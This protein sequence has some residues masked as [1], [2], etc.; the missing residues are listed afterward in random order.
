MTQKHTHKE[1]KE[2]EISTCKPPKKLT[3]KA[4]VTHLPAKLKPQKVAQ[5]TRFR[6]TRKK[7][8]NLQ[9]SQAQVKF[10]ENYFSG[11]ERE[12]PSAKRLAEP[13]QDNPVNSS[14]RQDLNP[15]GGDQDKLTSRETQGAT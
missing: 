6:K 9:P 7:I 14:D 4:D 11:A 12:R 13:S 10:I 2:D 1:K 3:S 15:K 5:Q 8:A